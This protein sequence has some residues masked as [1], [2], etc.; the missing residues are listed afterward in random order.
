MT[1]K[2]HY[3]DRAQV[4]LRALGERLLAQSAAMS[5]CKHLPAANR[6][7]PYDLNAIQE[8]LTAVAKDLARFCLLVELDSPPP[9]TP[10][11]PEAGQ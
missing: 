1:T 9:E 11:L 8:R 3:Y 10:Q 6:A 5:S 4:E 2:D 7:V